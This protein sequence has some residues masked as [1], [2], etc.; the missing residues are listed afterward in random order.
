MIVISDSSVLIQTKAV[1]ARD[2]TLF[3][4]LATDRPI[5]Y[6]RITLSARFA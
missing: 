3:R 4:P 5:L 6:C 1:T 2:Q